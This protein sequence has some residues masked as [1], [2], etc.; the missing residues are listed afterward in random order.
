MACKSFTVMLAVLAPDNKRQISFGMSKICQDANTA[1]YI[2]EFVLRDR[3]GDEFQDRVHL[4][5]DVGADNKDKDAAQKLMDRGM[6]LAQL[7]FL[8]GPVTVKAKNLKSGTTSDAKTENLIKE[9]PKI[10][11]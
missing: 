1:V 4:H 6:S 3:I 8:Q 10:K 7:Q 9:I 11:G 2:I 5:I